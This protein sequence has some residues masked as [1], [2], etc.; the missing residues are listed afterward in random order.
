MGLTKAHPQTLV[1]LRTFKI[2]SY[3]LEEV[4]SQFFVCKYSGTLGIKLYSFTGFKDATSRFTYLEKF[5]LNFSSS[6][7]SIHVVPL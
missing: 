1:S 3:N 7:F 4:K 2:G 6:S 5:S